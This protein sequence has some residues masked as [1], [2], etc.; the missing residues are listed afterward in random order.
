M[1]IYEFNYGWDLI[2]ARMRKSG[3]VYVDLPARFGERG[4]IFRESIVLEDRGWRFTS[5]QSDDCEYYFHVWLTDDG[6]LSWA[7]D[8]S[9]GIEY[10][11][12]KFDP[13]YPN[14]GYL[15]D[16]ALKLYTISQEVKK[17]KARNLPTHE[18]FELRK[19][20]LNVVLKMLGYDSIDAV[21][22]KLDDSKGALGLTKVVDG[23]EKYI[24]LAKLVHSVEKY[25]DEDLIKCRAKTEA[26]REQI[27]DYIR[28]VEEVVADYEQILKNRDAKLAERR[29]VVPEYKTKM[30]EK[31]GEYSWD[32]YEAKVKAVALLILELNADLLTEEQRTKLGVKPYEVETD[33]DLKDKISALI[34]TEEFNIACRVEDEFAFGESK[35]LVDRINTLKLDGTPGEPDITR[36]DVV[37]ILADELVDLE[38][39]KAS[40]DVQETIRKEYYTRKDK[41]DD[42][43]DDK[44]K[45]DDEY[46]Y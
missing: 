2:R 43:K 40:V 21:A 12:E 31:V 27:L 24:D 22:E 35:K 39:R 38:E 34:D 6:R 9:R 33:L 25:G 41:K 5:T 17:Y 14:A 26:T 45:T 16:T 7:N 1:E 10:C 36:E 13:D 42:N 15:N 23:L 11:R 28:P 29:R 18:V 19:C 4:G 8:M 3:S 30:K 20:Y 46:V 37:R 44:K 32:E